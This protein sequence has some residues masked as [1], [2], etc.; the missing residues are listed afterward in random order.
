MADTSEGPDEAHG[1]E[2]K[3]FLLQKL[4]WGKKDICI[5]KMFNAEVFFKL[6]FTLAVITQFQNSGFL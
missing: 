5:S 6:K 1:L 4:R 2:I 3:L